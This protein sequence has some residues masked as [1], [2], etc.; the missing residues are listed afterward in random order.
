MWLEAATTRA[1]Q[2][3]VATGVY[4]SDARQGDAKGLWEGK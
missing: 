3:R 4:G 2:A 1:K